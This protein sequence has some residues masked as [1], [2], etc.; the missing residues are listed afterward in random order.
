MWTGCVVVD[1]VEQRGQRRRLAAA[2]RAGDQ[3]QAGFFLRDLFKNRGQSQALDRGNLALQF[4]QDD[5]EMSLLPENIYAETRFVAERITAIAG[6]AGEIIVNETP[7]S[8][9]QASARF[10]RFDKE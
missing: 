10:A 7:I 5:R 1:L 6:A 8:L 9:H 3:D 4:S 2:G